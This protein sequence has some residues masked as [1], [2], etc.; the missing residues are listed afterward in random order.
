M[1]NKVTLR[2]KD[3][4][5]FNRTE[6]KG[7]AILLLILFGLLLANIFIPSGTT[8]PPINFT[9]FEKEIIIFENAWQKAKEE[10]ER[11]NK[12][13]FRS[14]FQKGFPFVDDS[15]YK[16]SRKPLIQFTIELNSADTF[17]LQRI[18]GIG[19]SF[20]RRIVSYRHRLGG[21]I[22]KEQLLEVFGMDSSR[23]FAMVPYIIVIPDSITK[24]DLNKITFKELLK[25]PYFSFEVTK[26]IMIYRKK[27]KRFKSLE[28]LKLIEGIDDSLFRRMVPY[29]RVDL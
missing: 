4:L 28:E 25:H 1:K 3:Y 13:H 29:L 26:A 17:D 22:Q 20:A 27:N 19:P 11:I 12:S 24:I 23:Y 5:T 15:V 10:E 2:I 14:S 18:R 9:V 8:M 16:I 7:I 21:Y 6:Q